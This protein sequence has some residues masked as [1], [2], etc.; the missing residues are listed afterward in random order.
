M[1]TSTPVS[2]VLIGLHAEIGAPIAEGLRPDWEVVRMIQSFE[3]AK[4]D[5]PYILQGQAPPTAPINS[6]GSGDYSRPVRAVI[7][8]RGFTQEQAETLYG[9]YSAEAK[10]PVLWVAGAAANRGPGTEPPP[11]VEK[12]M[13]PIFKEILKKGVEGGEGKGKSELVLY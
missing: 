3:A 5:L 6:V 9:L 2:I 4:A 11:G 8:G 1:S 10:E 7:F 12:I 13:V